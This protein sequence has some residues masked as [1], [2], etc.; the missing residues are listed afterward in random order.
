MASHHDFPGRDRLIRSIEQ[1]FVNGQMSPQRLCL[2]LQALHREGSV[3]LPPALLT[4]ASERYLRRRI[5]ACDRLGYELIAMTWGPA[6]GSPLHDHDGNWCVECLWQG[7]LSIVRHEPC[8]RDQDGRTRFVS[9]PATLS[10]TGEGDWLEGHSG[11]HTMGNPDPEIT[12]VSLHIYPRTFRQCGW[13]EPMEDGWHRRRACDV[14]LD[15]WP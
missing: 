9:H 2:A 6:Q 8:E 12:A 4:P 14:T 3:A 13:F 7:T 15:A 1:V 10:H 11:Y 5:H